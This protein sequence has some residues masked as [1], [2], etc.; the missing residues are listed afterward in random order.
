VLCAGKGVSAAVRRLPAGI[1]TL[2]VSRSAHSETVH[3]GGRDTSVATDAG[4]ADRPAIRVALL[5]DAVAVG[6]RVGLSGVL[7]TIP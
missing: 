5:L 3:A 6:Q 1:G 7:T 2:T 4:L